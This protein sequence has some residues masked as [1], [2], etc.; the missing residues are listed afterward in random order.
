MVK[1]N[2]TDKAQFH[3]SLP[4]FSFF[5]VNAFADSSL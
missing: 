3:E 5:D 4:V 2:V 1:F